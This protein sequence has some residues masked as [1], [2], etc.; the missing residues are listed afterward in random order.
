[1]LHYQP[2]VEIDGVTT[3]GVEL[4]SAGNTR[5]KLDEPPTVHPGCEES[6]LIIPIEPGFSSRRAPTASLQPRGPQRTTRFGG[7]NLSARQ[8]DDPRIV[9]TVEKILARTGLPPSADPGDHSRAPH[10]GRRIRSR[11]PP[12]LKGWGVVA[13]DDFGTGYSSLSYLQRFPW[14]S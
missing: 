3:V 12:A 7:V 13:I 11:R 6:G 9:A 1:M 5:T 8:I 4:S 14:T 2:V 10:A